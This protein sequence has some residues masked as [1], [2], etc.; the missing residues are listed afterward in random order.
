MSKIVYQDGDYTKV[1]RTSNYTEDETFVYV[2][3]GSPPIRLNKRFIISIKE[4]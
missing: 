4:E 3:D 2:K 1:I